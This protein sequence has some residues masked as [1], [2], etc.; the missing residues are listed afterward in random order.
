LQLKKGGC[1]TRQAGRSAAHLRHL[2][3]RV[4][5][6]MVLLRSLY[7]PLRIKLSVSLVNTPAQQE[8]NSLSAV[9]RKQWSDQPP[10]TTNSLSYLK[11]PPSKQVST[12]RK[13]KGL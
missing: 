1:I 4:T 10:T 2:V 11:L 5:A 7:A 8:R 6:G 13:G 3:V 12:L 9:G